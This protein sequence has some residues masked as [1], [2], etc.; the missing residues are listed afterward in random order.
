[1]CW[2][3]A[4]DANEFL[5][6]TGLWIDDI[7]ASK[8]AMKWPFQKVK[9]IN[10]NPDDYHFDLN[11]MSKE[12]VPFK[13]PMVFTIGPIDPGV[14]MEG[15]L[16]YA[17]KMSGLTEQQIKE[18]ISGVVHGETRVLSAKLTVQEMFQERK[19][20]KDEVHEQVAKILEEF[21]LHISNSNIAEMKDLD[22]ENKYFYNLKQKALEQASNQAKIDIAEEKKKGNVGETQRN[23]DAEVGMKE[24]E[25]RTTKLKNENEKQIAES[26]KNLQVARY[27]FTQEQETK[28]IETENAPKQRE[29]ELKTE[30]QKKTAQAK[31]EELR[32]SELAQSKVDAEKEIAKAHGDATAIERRA[33]ATLYEAQ[34]IAEGILAKTSAQA[35]GLQRFLDIKDPEMVKF[36]MAVDKNVFVDLAQK[37]ADA[38]QGMAPKINIWNTGTSND[39]NP[40][41]TIKELFTSLPPMLDAVQSQTNIKMPGWLPSSSA[42]SC[43]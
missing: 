27:Q 16:R 1:M 42:S 28:K 43:N 26:N 3:Y 35:E 5:V 29:Q 17:R 38:V 18:I 33:D 11:N 22:T 41:A 40:L 7:C 19:K 2:Y 20:F 6:K 30:L 23:C 4:C 37:T 12:L 9:F 15:F 25:A 34:K 39:S 36:F 10:L 13:L 21:G 8:K 31:L 32:A 24:I 14:D